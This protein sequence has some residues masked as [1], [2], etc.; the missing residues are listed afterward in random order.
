MY[1]SP[2]LSAKMLEIVGVNYAYANGS[3]NILQLVDEGDKLRIVDI[4]S[5]DSQ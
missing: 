3:E 4:D 1:L 5:V 2:I